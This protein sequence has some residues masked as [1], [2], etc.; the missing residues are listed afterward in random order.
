MVNPPQD[1]CLLK[2]LAQLIKAFYHQ[3]NS[4][5]LRF[6]PPSVPLT[7]VDFGT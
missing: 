1:F 4:K 6:H 5:V 3:K 2:E 7:G